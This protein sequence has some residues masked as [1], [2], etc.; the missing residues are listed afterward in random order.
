M[1]K[2]F[3]TQYRHAKSFKTQTKL[4]GFGYKAPSYPTKIQPKKTQSKVFASA[5]IADDVDEVIETPSTLPRDVNLPTE[6]LSKASHVIS[7]SELSDPSTDNDHVG[8]LALTDV[9]E[10][11]DQGNTDSDSERVHDD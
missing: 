1:S 6:G 9:G 3:H 5:P 8:V 7:A 4:T 10:E 11:A 2:S